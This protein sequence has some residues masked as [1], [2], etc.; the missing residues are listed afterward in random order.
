VARHDRRQPG[1]GRG[2]RQPGTAVGSAAQLATP[3]PCVRE[4]LSEPVGA[5]SAPTHGERPN[6]RPSNPSSSVRLP[7]SPRRGLELCRVPSPTSSSAALHVLVVSCLASSLLSHLVV[8]RRAHV[9]RRRSP[10]V[11]PLVRTIC[12][13]TSLSHDSRRAQHV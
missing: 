9:V 7:C 2:I 5:A 13:T 12:K 4:P 8:V 10:V 1:D 6:P 3:A 11:R